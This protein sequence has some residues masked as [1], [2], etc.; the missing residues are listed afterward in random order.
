MKAKKFKKKGL[1]ILIIGGVVVLGI[2]GLY[3]ANYIYRKGFIRGGVVGFHLT[4]DWFDKEFPDIK[5]R[6]L[7]DNWAN[8]HPEQI[9][10]V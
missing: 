10:T 8:L 2:A 5:L 3:G 4:I 6:E 9:V 7:Y 1:P